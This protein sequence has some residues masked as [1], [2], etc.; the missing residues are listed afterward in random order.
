MHLRID[1]AILREAEQDGDAELKELEEEADG[2]DAHQHSAAAAPAGAISSSNN[3][4]FVA[5][6]TA[7][8]V[9]QLYSIAEVQYRHRIMYELFI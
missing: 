2:D 8:C 3:A 4:S 5:P 7:V 6:P 1:E 9:S